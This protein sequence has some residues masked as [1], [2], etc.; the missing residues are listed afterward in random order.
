MLAGL[1]VTAI[2]PPAIAQRSATSVRSDQAEETETARMMLSGNGPDDA[3]SWDFVIDGGRR[4]GEKATIPVPSNWQQHGFGTYQFGKYDPVRAANRGT[5]SRQFTVPA[6]WQG[7]RIRLVFDGAMT[8]TR[9]TV[10]G[11][12][13]G[14]VHQGGFYRFAFDITKLVKIGEH[15]LVTVEVSEVSADPDT[16]RAE[17]NADYWVFGGIFRPVWLEATPLQAIEHVA[18]DARADGAFSADVSLTAPRLVTRVEGQ[19]RDASG[20]R[21]GTLFSTAI[22]SGGAG[23]VR[24]STRIDK[25]RLWNAETPHLYTLELALFEQDTLVHRTSQRFGFRTFEVR[26]GDGLYLN[27]QRLLL[28]GINRHSFRPD[29]ARA[30]SKADNYADVRMLRAMNMNAVRMSHYPPDESFLE[31]ADELGLYVLDELSGWQHAHGTEIGRRLVREMVERD[32]NHPSIVLWDNGNEGGFNRDLDADFALYDPQARAVLH[33][34]E[35]FGGID[36]KHYPKYADLVRRLGGPNLVMPTEFMHGMF[37]G[38]SGAGLADYWSA[39]AG[40][41]RGAGGFLWV[42][43]DEGIARTDRGGAIDNYATYAPDGV[44]GARHEKEPSYFAIRDLWSPVQ[45]APPRLDEAFDGRLK[46]TN[47]FDFTSLDAVR[48]TWKT[49]RF[50]RPDES[51]L[52]PR[53][54]RSGEEQTAISPQ[55]TGDLQLRLPADWHSSDALSLT[56][57]RGPDELRTWVWPVE[58]STPERAS[59]PGRATRSAGSTAPTS[60]QQG[61]AILLAARD[62]VAR[63]DKR[64]GLLIDIR[65]GGKA[66]SLSGGPRLVA[67]GARTTTPPEW[68]PTSGKGGVFRPGVPA[69]A[70]IVEVVTSSQ[71]SSGR[72]GWTGFKLEIGDAAGRWRT[73]FDGKRRKE[74]GQRYIFPPQQIAAI[75]ISGV[76]TAAGVPAAISSVRL[77]FEAARFASPGARQP[78]ITSGTERNPETGAM[79]AWIQADGAGGLDKARWILA[80]DGSLSLDYGYKLQGAYVYHGVGFD[81]PLETVTTV[82]GLLDGPRPV[83]QNRLQGTQLGIHLIAASKSPTL[84]DP[85][86]AGYFAGARWARFDTPRERW[87]VSASTPHYL[88]V[89]T[90]WNDHPNTTAAFPGGDVAFLNAIPAIGSKFITPED[91]GP[92]GMPAVANG[93]YTGRLTFFW[94]APGRR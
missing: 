15:N 27:G 85:T 55:T 11:V 17:R 60:T 68:T 76:Q 9:V 32:V 18:I 31:A 50:A 61:E 51:R 58:R 90:R 14:P 42:F 93:Q 2:S 10:N 45:I 49:L 35:L 34:W 63:F 47:N 89:G 43:A 13:A 70:N 3:V 86:Q 54:L 66:I 48:F 59:A 26:A 16:D 25:P 56:A 36:T 20:N 73:I 75:R 28:K 19:I 74:D 12:Q 53:T 40:S 5:Y 64:T 81:Y 91:S 33:P 7:R 37:D 24:L 88:R 78:V 44:V 80:P 77:G 72:E 22:P 52:S 82:R 67:M 39:I 84:P 65:R 83:W 21:V 29:T 57:S 79:Q 1:A 69:M 38:G 92:S 87:T 94:N 4:A 71:D 30:L 62:V 23:R 46:V 8:D 6:A 41:P